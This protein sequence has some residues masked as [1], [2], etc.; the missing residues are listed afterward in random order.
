VYIQYDFSKV[1]YCQH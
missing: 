1:K